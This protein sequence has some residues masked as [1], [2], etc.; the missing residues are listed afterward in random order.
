M[1]SHRH[2]GGS[3]QGFCGALGKADPG[4]LRR[5][6]A[7]IGPTLR[8]VHEDRRA[9]LWIQG[10]AQR[11][12]SGAKRGIRWSEG[13]PELAA[14]GRRGD[15][16]AADCAGLV[17]GAVRAELHPSVSGRTPVYWVDDG[18]ATYF[19]SRVGALADTC[20]RTLDPD[21]R[22]WASIIRVGYAIGE[23]T[24]FAQV[25][26]L[27]PDG[28]L[29]R[30]GGAA[31]VTRRAWGWAEVEPTSEDE[32]LEATLAALDDV[33]A[34]FAS[35]R[36]RLPLS[37]GGDSRLLLGAMLRNPPGEMTAVTLS[38]QWGRDD[39]ERMAAQLTDVANVPHEVLA[40]PDEGYWRDFRAILERT[41][42]R[43]A[44]EW[45]WAQPL[46]EGL[47]AEGAVA[48]DGYAGDILIA[49]KFAP[50]AAINAPEA[51]R[52]AMLWRRFQG[53][54]RSTGVLTRKLSRAL[55]RTARE[56]LDLAIAPW[57]EH[58][59]GST[60]ATYRTR[61][62]GGMSAGALILN[63]ALP[64]YT[65]FVLDAVARASL[66]C[67]PE[68]RA[69]SGFQRRLLTAAAPRLAG[70]ES[71]TFGETAPARLVPA[72]RASG[73]A[74]SEQIELLR[75]S[76]LRGAFRGPLREAVD[77]GDPKRLRE[78]RARSRL[79]AGIVSFGLWSERYEARL[80]GTAGAEGLLELAQG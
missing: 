57:M 72:R 60:L 21:W 76:P 44:M 41:D 38:G 33:A 11:W 64:T 6:A 63:E 68:R 59:N 31:K 70:I 1:E 17:L 8:P 32:A 5:M 34:G 19:A 25:R 18:G 37:G 35:A 10:E 39:D 30:V 51:E 28:V 79:L 22:A 49:G 27:P 56:E 9:S 73:A 80:A 69:D 4:R 55:D 36:M 45:A 61:T 78:L 62:T 77:A 12:R 46:A 29:I 50:A 75:R 14:R 54:R 16:A 67:P 2:N 7:A 42:H 40:A 20:E 13:F 71:T 43:Q 74:L 52:A 47:R 66:L 48:V 26:R 53:G 23:R 3:L 58:R 65:P 15:P 24:P